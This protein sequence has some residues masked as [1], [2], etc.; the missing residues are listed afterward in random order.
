VQDVALHEDEIKELVVRGYTEDPWFAVEDNIKDLTTSYGLFIKGGCI[1]VPDVPGLRNDIMAEMH[2]PLSVRTL[3]S[4]RQQSWCNDTIGGRPGG[5]MC[6]V[7]CGRVIH[8][9]AT[10]KRHNYRQGNCTPYQFLT[11]KEGASAWIS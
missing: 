8:A 7:L 2:T 1:V 9:N 6:Q 5:W 10:R 4:A 11:G 3:A